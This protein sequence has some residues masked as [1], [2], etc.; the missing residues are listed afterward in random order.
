MSYGV[1]QLTLIF[2]SNTTDFVRLNGSWCFSI[3]K[4][5]NSLPFMS[6]V[7]FAGNV[8]VFRSKIN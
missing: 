6:N 1:C 7:T 5:L 3:K 4:F 2:E 8:F